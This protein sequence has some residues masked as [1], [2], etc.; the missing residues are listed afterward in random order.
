[1]YFQD[2]SLKQFQERLEKKKHQRS[3]LQTLFGVHHIPKDAQMRNI[4][5][6][7]DSES[8]SAIFADYYERLRR[9]KHLESY[10]VLPDM[11]L[12]VMDSTQYH[13][14]GSIHC[15]G[16]LHKSHQEGEVTYQHAVSQGAIMH[17]E[18]RQVLPVMPEAIHNHDGETKQDCETNAAKRFVRHLKQAHPQQVFLLGGDSLMSRQPLIEE[19][20]G[21]GMHI[22]FTAKCSDHVY[23][24]EWLDAFKALPSRESIDKTGKTHRFRLSTSGSFFIRIT[25][26]FTK[27][28]PW[29]RW[30]FSLLG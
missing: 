8:F 18:K 17:P 2:S 13:S 10:Q 7:L 30:P 12:C 3:N 21:Q 15:A 24:Y 9:H 23:M 26:C 11:V 16:C 29:N 22:L 28:L 20:L 14:S 5:D 4:L 25:G 1:M 19:A 27:H 6:E